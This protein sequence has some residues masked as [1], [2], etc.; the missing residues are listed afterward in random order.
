METTS[1]TP[2]ARTPDDARAALHEL[3]DGRND[4]VVQAL[5]TILTWQ[6][7]EDEWGAC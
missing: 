3:R 7:P 5:L 6:D 4:A 2:Q 1:R